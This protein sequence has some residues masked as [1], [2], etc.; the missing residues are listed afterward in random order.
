MR[1]LALTL[2]CLGCAPSASPPITS[3]RETASTGGTAQT[4]GAPATDP[5]AEPLAVPEATRRYDSLRDVDWQNFTY[6]PGLATLRDGYSEYREYSEEF[7]GLHDT[8]IWKLV[9][10]A[11]GDWGRNG[12]DEAIVLVS[13]IYSPPNG[14]GSERTRV[15][16]YQLIDG[17]VSALGDSF[18]VG[19]AE[20]AAIYEDRVS[21]FVDGRCAMYQLSGQTWSETSEDC[22][23]N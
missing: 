6:I 7:G 15:F 14:P 22:P 13:E 4:V 5:A 16:V 23:G 18:E 8:T 2:C 17:E 3:P 11:L 19:V 21:L 10:V 12:T 20:S 9:T 1:W